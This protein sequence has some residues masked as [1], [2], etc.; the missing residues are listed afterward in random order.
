MRGRMC[1]GRSNAA[2]RLVSRLGLGVG[3]WAAALAGGCS[4]CDREEAG[5][6]AGLPAKVTL[7]S[8]PL[9]GLQA[10][11][12]ALVYGGTAPLRTL[13]ASLSGFAQQAQVPVPPLEA[14]LGVALKAEL[15][16]K[17]D[18]VVD[19]GKSMRFAL[20]NPKLHAQ[21]PVALLFGATQKDAFVAAL[22]DDRKAD[23]EGNAFSFLRFPGSS[24]AVYVNF[25][26]DTVVVTRDKTIFPKYREFLER[27]AMAD[28]DRAGGVI[29]AVKNLAPIYGADLDAALADIKK[30]ARAAI[31]AIPGAAGQAWMVDGLTEAVGRWA[32]ELDQVRLLVDTPAD[33]LRA[34]LVFQ[35]KPDGDLQKS[36]A[37]LRGPGTGALLDRMPADAPFFLWANVAPERLQAISARFAAM[38][39]GAMFKADPAKKQEYDQA[40]V[41][42]LAAMNGEMVV[43]A[44]GPVQGDGLSVSGILGISDADKARKSQAKLATVYQE[45]GAV[46]YYKKIGLEVSMQPAAYTVGDVPVSVFSTKIGDSN[47]QL[48]SMRGGLQELLTQHVGISK[49]A[50]VLAIGSDARPTVEA[51]L[52]GTLKGGLRTAEGPGRALKLAAPN[53]VAVLYV[54][55]IELARRVRLGGMNPAAELLKDISAKTGLALS[56][57]TEAGALQVVF[58]L[59]AEQMQKIGQVMQKTKGTF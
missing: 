49:D 16:L 19:L 1:E 44:H 29:F 33:G 7:L 4:S 57:G 25:V 8:A 40:M 2:R 12:D 24:Q 42:A 17:D 18:K 47:P 11:P 9:E 35:P 15:N 53:P 43:A 32:R 54:S 31:A 13:L 14:Q 30:N 20:L 48:A 34:Q 52:G 5:G 45:P 37:T 58:D 51:I 28:I 10:P 3:L 21:A 59:P 56:V 46:E 41:D 55:P 38:T 50:C 39:V 36:F 6:Q 23:D 26:L 27:L 22:P